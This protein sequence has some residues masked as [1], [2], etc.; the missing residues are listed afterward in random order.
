MFRNFQHTLLKG[1]PITLENW[2]RI[3]KHIT[4]I[5]T[6]LIIHILSFTQVLLYTE[7][8]SFKK[9]KI[10]LWYQ[11]LFSSIG[12]VLFCFSFENSV[13]MPIRNI[14]LENFRLFSVKICRSHLLFRLIKSLW[15]L[16]NLILQCYSMN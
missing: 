2:L 4:K 13:Q 14:F 3:S 1:H 5:V 8:W 16:V 10:A 9:I 15:A 7:I 11:Y 6:D 12:F